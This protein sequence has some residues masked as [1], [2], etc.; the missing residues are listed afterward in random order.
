[1]LVNGGKEFYELV[2]NPSSL[3]NSFS[4]AKK[5]FPHDDGDNEER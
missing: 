3:V 1:V 5:Q 2:T 4:V